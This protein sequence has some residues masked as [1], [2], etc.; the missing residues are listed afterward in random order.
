[1]EREGR[2]GWRGR[3]GREGWRERV[4]FLLIRGKTTYLL[5]LLLLLGRVLVLFNAPGLTQLL[6]KRATARLEEGGR[7]RGGEGGREVRK[8]EMT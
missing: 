3:E 4:L 5:F 2:E 7:E 6:Q 1:M 8:R